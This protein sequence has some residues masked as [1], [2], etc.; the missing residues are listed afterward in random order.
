MS[1]K[2]LM[3]GS[4]LPLATIISTTHS[5]SFQQFIYAQQLTLALDSDPILFLF[6]SEIQNWLGGTYR[7]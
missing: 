5:A 1:R 4:D 7:Q 2:S 3:T 6:F